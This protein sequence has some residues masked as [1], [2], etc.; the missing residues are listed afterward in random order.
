MELTAQ[1]VLYVLKNSGIVA[2]IAAKMDPTADPYNAVRIFLLHSALDDAVALP[3][4]ASKVNPSGHFVLP[5]KAGAMNAINKAGGKL[6]FPINLPFAFGFTI[7]ITGSDL[8]KLYQTAEKIVAA[9][10]QA[11]AEQTESEP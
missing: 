7:T 5:S 11:Q 9:D 4:L 2:D 1:Q 10:N 8:E 3:M 6:V